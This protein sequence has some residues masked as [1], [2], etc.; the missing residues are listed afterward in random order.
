MST[1]QSTRARTPEGVL[2]REV[3]SYLEGLAA[4]GK[5]MLLR[6]NAGDFIEVRGRY[7][8]RVKGCPKGTAD[9]LVV[10]NSRIVF[11][12]L[13][14]PAGRQTPE[15]QAFEQMAKARGCEYHIIHSVEEVKG[16]IE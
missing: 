16:V 5:L 6:L 7:R 4:W 11:L 3:A 9:L 10:Y 15:Q 2:K 13:K 8:R 12:E 14:G 1:K